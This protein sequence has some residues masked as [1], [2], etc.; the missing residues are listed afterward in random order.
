MNIKNFL[1]IVCNEIKYKP[2]KQEISQEI[3]SH[4]KEIKEDYIECGM[5]EQEAEEKAIEQMGNA[6]EI[7]K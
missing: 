2:I 5:K 1:E 3:E 7:G 6:E 4:I